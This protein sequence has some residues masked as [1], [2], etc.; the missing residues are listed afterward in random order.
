MGFDLLLEAMDS[1]SLD[2]FH[3]TV[4]GEAVEKSFEPPASSKITYA[5]WLA[6][7]AVR[8]HIAKSDVLI[9]PSRWESFCLV[10]AEA[11]VLGLPVIA[12]NHCSLPEIVE[13]ARTGMLFS[14]HSASAIAEAIG[15][16]TVEMLAKMGE[17]ALGLSRH[18]FTLEEMNRL[19]LE[20]YSA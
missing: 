10:A 7:A 3:L 14:P 4:V 1:L 9:V 16:C 2:A 11:Q 18:R 19:T 6:P 13:N 12:G 20:S 17:E 8:E 5:G 15:A